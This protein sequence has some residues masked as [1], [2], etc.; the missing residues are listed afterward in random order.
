M[1]ATDSNHGWFNVELQVGNL[2]IF[3]LKGLK[4][5]GSDHLNYGWFT[6]WWSVFLQ[7]SSW[8]KS[9]PIYFAEML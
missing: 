3:W 4:Q 7:R 5:N 1:Q 6:I 2:S 9:L 8:V